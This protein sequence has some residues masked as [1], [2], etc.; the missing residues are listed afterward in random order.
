MKTERK[1]RVVFAISYDVE[2]ENKEDA[3]EKAIEKLEKEFGKKFADI[4]LY[5][6]GE[7]IEEI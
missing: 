7:N 4:V 3:E 6:F 2:A 1:Y 5:Y